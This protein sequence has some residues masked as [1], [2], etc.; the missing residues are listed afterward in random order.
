MNQVKVPTDALCQSST[1][2]FPQVYV[3]KLTLF[4]TTPHTVALCKQKQNMSQ[5]EVTVRDVHYGTFTGSGIFRNLY[6][7]SKISNPILE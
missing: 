2:K 4:N 5:T 6:F 1:Q 7:E 3:N